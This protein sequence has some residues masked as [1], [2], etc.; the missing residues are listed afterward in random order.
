MKK[1]YIILGTILLLWIVYMG[2][3]YFRCYKPDTTDNKPL[4][5]IKTEDEET[6]TS[7]VG[8]GFSVVRY[9]GFDRDAA[10]YLLQIMNSLQQFRAVALPIVILIKQF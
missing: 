6:Y 7:D 4:I 8:L 5:T 1:V 9:K 10:L 2:V 3:E